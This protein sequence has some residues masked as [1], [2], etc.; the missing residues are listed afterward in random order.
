[1]KQSRCRYRC[2]RCGDYRPDDELIFESGR[3]FPVCED[4]EACRQAIAR[5]AWDPSS[6]VRRIAP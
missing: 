6:H 2:W 4:K 3:L 1:M 5:K